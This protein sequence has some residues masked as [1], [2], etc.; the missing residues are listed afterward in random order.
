[1]DTGPK[2]VCP[3]AVYAYNPCSLMSQDPLEQQ[4]HRL[5]GQGPDHPFAPVTWAAMVTLRAVP[6]P[7]PNVPTL[8]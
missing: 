4:Q 5:I 2:G 7:F 8:T 1:M 3:I 6:L